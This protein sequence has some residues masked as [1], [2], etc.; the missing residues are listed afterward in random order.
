MGS[1]VE[2]RSYQQ[3]EREYPGGITTILEPRRLESED[4]NQAAMLLVETYLA[5]AGR[6]ILARQWGR[7]WPQ[8]LN[9]DKF[10]PHCMGHAYD[11]IEQGFDP[12]VIGHWS[13][14]TGST[15]MCMEPVGVYHLADA[16]FAAIDATAVSYLY[17]RGLDV[18]AAAILAATVAEAMKPTATV[19][20]VCNAALAAAPRDKFNTFDRRRFKNCHDYL[21]RCLDV[22]DR[23][24]DV[25]AARRELY[26]KCL[27][28]FCIDPL[29]LLGL[30]LAMFRIADGDV[31]RAAIGG[32][33]LGRDADSIAGRAAM[34][35]GTLRGE[36]NIPREWIRLFKPH[37]IEKITRNA[38]R[39]AELIVER[40][41]PTLQRRRDLHRTR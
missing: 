37:V 40:K 41:L 7:T 30:A 38:D 22:A 33:N 20:S 27:M 31:R 8:R 10:Y 2:G 19:A 24:D 1:P 9:R 26:D 14:V 5:H 6:P 25:M 15:V 4:D 3:I 29:E 17:Q 23:F 36:A 28:Y 12:R 13:V 39:L 35:A 11:L 16:E 32:T 21:R 18:T 34:L